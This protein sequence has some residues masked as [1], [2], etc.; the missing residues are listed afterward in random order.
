MVDGVDVGHV[1]AAANTMQRYV[2]STPELTGNTAL[3]FIS[4]DATASY[5]PGIS[6]ISL[7]LGG[8]KASYTNYLTHCVP[9]SDLDLPSASNDSKAYSKLIS[10]GQLLIVHEGKLYNAQGTIL[11]NTTHY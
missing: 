5:G 2:W 10:D 7:Y 9:I 6:E 1:S 8:Q 4:K 3:T 11:N